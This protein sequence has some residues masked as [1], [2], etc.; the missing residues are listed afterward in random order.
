M[1]ESENKSNSKSKPPQ[2]KESEGEVSSAMPALGKSAIHWKPMENQGLPS[3]E[4]A[5]PHTP[6][7]PVSSGLARGNSEGQN[8]FASF[9]EAPSSRFK[10]VVA[11]S[12]SKSPSQNKNMHL[13]KNRK[14]SYDWILANA[15][16]EDQ[17]GDHF[18]NQGDPDSGVKRLASFLDTP[19]SKLA[20][21]KGLEKR[22]NQLSNL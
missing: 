8:H 4:G 3:G 17:L 2:Q 11:V 21:P 12:S 18:Q 19:L 22:G 1:P 13:I 6:P 20:A 15:P 5:V 7:L 16:S 14:Q 10:D 9:L